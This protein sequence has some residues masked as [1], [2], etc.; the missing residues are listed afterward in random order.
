MKVLFRM[1]S[2][3]SRAQQCPASLHVLLPRRCVEEYV[4]RRVRTHHTNSRAIEKSKVG[5]VDV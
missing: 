4:T 3:L 5:R 2:V 1:L